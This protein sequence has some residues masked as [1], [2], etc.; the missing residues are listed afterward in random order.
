MV[1]S[2]FSPFSLKTSVP[3]YGSFFLNSTMWSQEW[4]ITCYTIYTAEL[5]STFILVSIIAYWTLWKSI[6]LPQLCPNHYL[7][8]SILYD[9][10]LVQFCR[11]R[12][13]YA[14]NRDS[15]FPQPVNHDLI[16]M[17]EQG[18]PSLCFSIDWYYSHCLRNDLN[19]HSFPEFASY[20]TAGNLKSCLTEDLR[21][22]QEEDS[23]ATFYKIIPDIYL[24]FP[25]VTT[26]NA[27]LLHLIVS[28]IDSQQLHTI[29]CEFN[30]VVFSVLKQQG[31]FGI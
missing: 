28:C 5:S 12:Y 13:H 4:V 6:N 8:G 29:V 17:K 20:T 10:I 19:R 15:K 24:K 22:C 31:G 26:G 11:I 9:T 16:S 27:N 30:W 25:A 23:P 7:L 1:F 21:I 2:N 14:W 3:G 18:C